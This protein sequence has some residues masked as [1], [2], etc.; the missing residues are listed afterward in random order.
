MRTHLLIAAILVAAFV[1]PGCLDTGKTSGTGREPTKFRAQPVDLTNY[2]KDR[3][4][5]S[6]KDIKP[7]V[8][9]AKDG[10]KL[11]GHVYIPDGI[12]PFATILEYSP[13]HN[14]AVL[15][16]ASDQQVRT[17]DG[18]RTMS[19]QYQAFMDAGYAV[20]IINLRGTGISQGCFQ[21]GTATDLE[22][23]YL[24]VE[25][26]AAQP[27]SDGQV[28]MIGTS[29]PGWTQYMALAADPP[30]LKAVIPVSGVIDLHSLLTRNG[31]PLSIGPAV[32]TAWEALF[33]IG[34]ATYPPIDS[35]GGEA[36]HLECGPTYSQDL[37]ESLTL[38]H[39]GDRNAYWNARD[40]R[41]KLAQSDVPIL[42]T[43]GLT[44]GEGH[45][46]Q[47]EG[48]WESI[49]HENKR[50]MIGQWGH[51]GTSHPSIDWQTMR[52]AWFDQYLR[53]SG[54]W[55]LLPNIVE[56]QDD[57]RKWHT[58]DAWPPE[59]NSTALHLSDRSLVAETEGVRSSTQTFQSVYANPCLGVCTSG[60]AYAPDTENLPACGPTQALYVSPPLAE[61]VLL[62]G[63]FHVN[64]TVTSS[65][66]DGNFAVYLYHTKGPG[67]C[68]D[69]AA[70]EV[71]RA[72]TDLRHPTPGHPGAEFPV[73]TPTR[74][75]LVSH[76]FAS[77]V[78]A[79]SRLVLAIGGGSTELT[80]EA[81]LPVLTVTAG[82]GVAGAL[83]LPVVE[84]TLRFT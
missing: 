19:G 68:P 6:L 84:G 46:L 25:T 41:P 55:L 2:G 59:H 39:N 78:P 3:P 10:I 42:F 4:L 1:L 13:Y 26:L 28:G 17:V 62:A 52:V 40:L 5:H 77:A 45:I 79:G 22:D 31:A 71:R 60:L 69:A 61:D 34:E 8:A 80:P 56:Y 35:R 73:N 9:T 27:W 76:P 23:V 20:A 81:R 24:V 63:N 70:K 65:L 72:L 83:T 48:L 44:D 67:T 16:G 43:N 14:N 75:D 74:M 29:Y 51:G 38:A 57:T 11:K 18:R 47:F 54:D 33:S 7:F 66:P 50:M 37:R 49:P 82:S 32:T 15:S 36:N 53:G 12:G 30:S 21:W 64:L 58:T